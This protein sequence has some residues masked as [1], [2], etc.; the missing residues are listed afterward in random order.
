MKH[1]LAVLVALL[2]ILS[3]TFAGTIVELESYRAA[4]AQGLC[5][6]AGTDYAADAAAR[7]ARDQC[8]I[9]TQSQTGPVRHLLNA[10]GRLF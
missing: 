10:L 4:N 9:A 5:H 3:W 2:A 1:L 7:Q 6:V 8:L